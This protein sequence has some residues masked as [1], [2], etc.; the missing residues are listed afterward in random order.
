MER[1]LFRL[2]KV[3]VGIELERCL[4]PA[5][6]LSLAKKY[7]LGLADESEAAARRML[8]FRDRPSF[9]RVERL[10]FRA[11][12]DP[13]DLHVLT[14]DLLAEQAIQNIRH[15]EVHLRL[16]THLAGGVDGEALYQA[17]AEAARDG[18]RR[19]GVAVRF[20]V[21][22]RP[23]DGQGAAEQALE[24][25]GTHASGTHASGTHLSNLVIGLHLA[26]GEQLPDPEFLAVLEA[27][28]GRGLHRTAHAATPEAARTLLDDATP[29]R[30]TL[31]APAVTAE[32][33][34]ALTS[35]G[36]GATLRPVED[37][38]FGLV[39]DLGSHPIATCHEHEAIALATGGAPLFGTNLTREYVNLQRFL[40][41]TSED[42]VALVR[43]GVR[44]SFLVE[45]K[46]RALEEKLFQA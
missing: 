23:E 12:R 7:K 45:E 42:L 24:W 19:H 13:Q 28:A 30:L 3:E 1:L 43:R 14:L 18:E 25:A 6:F 33:L 31:N 4:R 15:S 37:L 9:E 20:L 22:V 44:Q 34:A 10:I 26:N 27:A 17:L 2:P 38:R 8:H 32:V 29:E 35:G 21:S 39:P 36:V 46:K 5:Q 11:L 41:T 16:A 40:G